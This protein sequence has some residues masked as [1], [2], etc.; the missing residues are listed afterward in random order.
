MAHIDYHAILH[1]GE[2]AETCCPLC[3]FLTTAEENYFQSMLYSWIGTEGFQNRFLS[4][5][6]FCTHHQQRFSQ[7]GDGIAVAMLYG[8]LMAHRRRWILESRQP[9][10]WRVFK[11]RRS[12]SPAVAAGHRAFSRMIN[13]TGCGDC[14][15]CSQ[16]HQWETSFLSNLARHGS[17]SSPEA[18]ELQRVYTRGTGLC[19]PHYARL[20]AHHR[21]VPPWLETLQNAREA[22]VRRELENYIKAI[23]HEHRV[24]SGAPWQEL[25]AYMEGE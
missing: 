10:L 23:Q 14:P 8:P 19:M 15:V 13:R 12:K 6:G 22:A 1:A 7:L 20:C 3:S 25:L 17:G 18:Q 11:R 21:S 16:R 2:E 4:H 5:N 24:V 9:R